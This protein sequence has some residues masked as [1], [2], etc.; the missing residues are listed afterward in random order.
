MRRLPF[1][2]KIGAGLTPEQFQQGVENGTL[3][4]VGFAESIQ[5]IADAVG[6]KLDRVTDE[7]TKI[8]SR[9]VE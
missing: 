2:R 4:H 8:A 5:M 3:R 6:W 9:A 7:V 1:Q